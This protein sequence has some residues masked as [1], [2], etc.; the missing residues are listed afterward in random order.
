MQKITL[1]LKLFF[2]FFILINL[3]RLTM[4]LEPYGIDI[5]ELPISGYLTSD[6]ETKPSFYKNI[7]AYMSSDGQISVYDLGTNKSRVI[8]N[9]SFH[10]KAPHVHGDYVLYFGYNRNE[11]P[12]LINY[13][14]LTNESHILIP[15]FPLHEFG[16]RY[17]FIKNKLISYAD[18]NKYPSDIQTQCYKNMYPYGSGLVVIDLSKNDDYPIPVYLGKCGDMSDNLRYLYQNYLIKHYISPNPREPDMCLKCNLFTGE[19]IYLP[20]LHDC[21]QNVQ[22]GCDYNTI[23][24][25]SIY[26]IIQ[27]EKDTVCFF[28]YLGIK[29]LPFYYDYDQYDSNIFF[30]KQDRKGYIGRIKYG[31]L[32]SL[33]SNFSNKLNFN[34]LFITTNCSIQNNNYCNCY[35]SGKDSDLSYTENITFNLVNMDFDSTNNLFNKSY[36][37]INFKLNFRKQQIVDEIAE[38]RQKKDYSIISITILAI[39]FFVLIYY[40]IRHHQIEKE[41]KSLEEEKRVEEARKVKKKLLEEKRRIRVEEEFRKFQEAKGLVEFID[42]FGNK[43]WGRRKEVEIWVKED[44]EAIIKESLFSKVIDTIKEFEPSRKYGN[45]ESYHAELHGWIKKS[46]PQAKIEYQ[47]GA[48]RPDIV[49]DDVAIEVKGPTDSQALDTLTTKCLKYSH[50]YK[51]LIIVLFEPKFSERNY[52]EIVSGIKKYFPNVKVIRKD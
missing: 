36:S 43:K 21:Q 51:N 19:K 25:N 42:R 30:F 10:V 6:F 34:S 52:Y 45:E 23:K 15:E 1:T 44:K 37:E 11:N 7:I 27:G 31:D 39:A 29:L 24:A 14:L 32:N 13:N 22:V 48:S 16:P 2:S 4:A 17:S 3:V 50:Y 38:K 12:D 28:E 8:V 46:F 18:C 20:Y 9:S 26:G 35:I 41:R 33:C 49:I 47:K 40:S 5:K